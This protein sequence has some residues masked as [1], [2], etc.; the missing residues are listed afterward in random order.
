MLPTRNDDS[1]TNAARSESDAGATSGWLVGPAV[2]DWLTHCVNEAPTPDSDVY[3]IQLG[4]AVAL[5]MSATTPP[6]IPDA[7]C[8]SRRHHTAEG[9]SARSL[10]DNSINE[11]SAVSPEV[12][13]CISQKRFTW[14]GF[15]QLGICSQSPTCVGGRVVTLGRAVWRYADYL[16]TSV[17]FVLISFELTAVLEESAFG[18]DT[19]RL[20]AAVVGTVIVF[21]T[22]WMSDW[23]AC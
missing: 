12:A 8:L 1:K 6:R 5:P 2:I 16:I 18:P 23:S 22:M 15:N 17:V 7:A 14:C 10:A 13:R 11:Q 4:G 21:R 9:L 3:V 19:I 20:T